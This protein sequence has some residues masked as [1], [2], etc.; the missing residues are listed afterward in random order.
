MVELKGSDNSPV[1]GK[2]H[3]Q[4]NSLSGLEP[5]LSWF[6]QLHQPPIPASVW[7]RCQLALIEGFTNVVCHAHEGKPSDTPIDIEVA[8]FPEHLEIRIWDYGAPFDLEQKIRELIKTR[9]LNKTVDT[10]SGRGRGLLL[11]SDISDTLT[12]RRD[13]DNRNCLLI[14]KRYWPQISS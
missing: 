14:V 11:M 4:V 9:E 3:L 1:P 6:A 7:L 13:S 10:Y 8:L 12:Y 2:A 5:V